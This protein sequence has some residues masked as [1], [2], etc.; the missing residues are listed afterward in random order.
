MR[1]AIIIASILFF[2]FTIIHGD[3]KE[4]ESLIGKEVSDFSLLNVDGKYISTQDYKGAKGFIVIFT[5]NHCPFA[6]LYTDRLQQL[7]ET[8]S[9]LGVPVLAINSMDTVVYEEEKFAQMQ[10]VAKR[11]SLVF[12]FLQ[13][14][15]QVVGQNFAASR[16]P[17]AFVIWKRENKWV[18]EY[19]G[20]IDDNGEH[21]ELATPF[22]ANAV[23]ELLLDKPVSN[24]ETQAFGCKI[25]YR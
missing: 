23:N 16:T 2:S 24:P 19:S 25:F 15:A 4:V 14:G 10:L 18:I 1:T 3:K 11:D 12:P 9:A 13:D 5:C 6:K 7:H 22:I 20:A 8:F 17:Q 21:P